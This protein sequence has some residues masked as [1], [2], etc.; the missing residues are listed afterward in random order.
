[1]SFRPATLPHR[2]LG[3]M[4]IGS[5]LR[6]G[7]AVA[8]VLVLGACHHGSDAIYA[9]RQA[10][11]RNAE[12]TQDLRLA[13]Q[14]TARGAPL[15]GEALRA[16]VAGRT[17]V[18]EFG[19]FPNGSPGSF[20]TQEYF[21]EDG[22]FIWAH[23][24]IQGEASAVPGDTWQVDGDRLCIRHQYWSQDVRC[25]SAAVGAQ[26]EIQLYIDAPGTPNHGLLTRTIGHTQAGPPQ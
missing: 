5:G 24:W 3:H 19:A 20:R 8:L 4:Q 22:Q 1:M 2:F 17:W 6:P 21:R 16:L 18:S 11:Q 26:G 14:Q 9:Q 23:N 12:A 10:E 13:T 7:F 15:A 25:Y